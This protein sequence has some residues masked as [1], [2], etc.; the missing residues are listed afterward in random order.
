MAE[1]LINERVDDI[2]VLLHVLEGMGLPRIIN[3]V[4]PSHGNWGG[5]SIGETC[6][7]WIGHILSTADHRL[8]HVQAWAARHIN[9]LSAILGKEVR[10]LDFSDDRICLILKKLSNE[11]IWNSIESRLNQECFR[12][13]AVL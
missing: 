5:L 4:C 3:E 8:S 2:P 7:G 9:I 11:E 13:Y 1:S 10:E 12:V 6:S